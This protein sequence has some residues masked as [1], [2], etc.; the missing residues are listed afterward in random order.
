VT[1]TR[2]SA[3]EEDAPRAR[4]PSA[5]DASAAASDARREQLARLGIETAQIAGRG[6]EIAP[7]ALSASIEGFVGFARVPIGVFGPL[8]VR[9]E[10]AQGDFFVPMATSEGA[11]VASMQHVANVVARSGGIVA[12]CTDECLWRAPV[13]VF[14]GLEQAVEFARWVPSARAGLEQVVAEGSRF[15]RLTR[16]EPTVVGCEV[17]LRLGFVT[18]DA[19]GQNMITRA[20]DSVCTR[21]L[22]EAPVKP[23][24]WLIESNFSGD[25]KAT[26]LALQG[27]RG[28]RVSAELVLPDK[29]C[30]RYFRAPPGALA[31][32][33]NLAAAGAAQSGTVGAQGNYANALAALFIACGQDV[34]C[35]AEAVAGLTRVRVTDEGDLYFSVTLPNLIV[36]SVGGGTYL[37]TARECLEMLGCRAEGG[38]RKLAEICAAV[39]LVAELALGGALAGGSFARIHGELGRRPEA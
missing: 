34:A 17:Y 16:L 33:W 19:A 2:G 37:P 24:T 39:V 35:V 38:A 6:A 18:G 9:G 30:R 15:C 14:G 31:E 7:E 29:L 10:S 3:S 28:K 32:S 1:P 36:G 5:T 25:K 21:L 13:F 27:A 8:R 22:D 12:R 26:V 11:L 23:R 4:L 20:S